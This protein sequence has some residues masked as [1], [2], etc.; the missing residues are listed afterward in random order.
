MSC[1]EVR[2]YSLLNN[3]ELYCNARLLIA[4]QQQVVLKCEGTHR[5]TTM[6]CIEVRD[7]S[8]LNNKGKKR[9]ECDI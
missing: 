3:N 9:R 1:I 7:Y 5:Q 8:L 4:K 6:S 2:D